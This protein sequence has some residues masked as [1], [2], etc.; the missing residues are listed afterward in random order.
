MLEIFI[1]NSFLVSFYEHK[2]LVFCSRILSYS[3]I[4]IEQLI[5]IIR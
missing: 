5:V 1:L 4:Q 3:F 2:L